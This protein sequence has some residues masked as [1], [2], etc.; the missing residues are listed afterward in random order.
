MLVLALAFLA[1][2]AVLGASTLTLMSAAALQHT[3]AETQTAKRALVEGA[4]AFAFS[5][6]AR[7]G[8]AACTPGSPPTGVKS[9][10]AVTPS[11][12]ILGYSVVACSIG[13][14]SAG[15]AG[16][17]CFFCV[18][19]S[20]SGQ[21]VFVGNKAAVSI[22]APTG[23]PANY[24]GAAI[25]DNIS[26][27][28]G[29]GGICS[30]QQSDAPGTCSLKVGVVAGSSY[31][32][33]TLGSPGS[34][35]QVAS[36]AIGDPL[37][38]TY[39][40]PTSSGL[41]V[42]PSPCGGTLTAGGNCGVNTSITQGIYSAINVSNGQLTL[43]PGVY[44]VT[45][46]FEVSGHGNIS[47]SGVTLFFGCNPGGGSTTWVACPAQTPATSATA[48]TTCSPTSPPS[49]NSFASL[50]GNGNVTL[51]APTAGPYSGLVVYADP[52]NNSSLCVSGSGS[53]SL[54][55]NGALYGRSFGLDIGGNGIASVVSNLVI[56]A[57]NIHVSSLSN[58]LKLGTGGSFTPL[59]CEFLDASLTA[60]PSSGGPTYSGRVVFQTNCP[61]AG[62][63]AVVSLSYSS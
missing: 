32:T 5:D 60:K 28:G 18:L 55:L 22:T 40:A 41:S 47:G 11:G 59:G 36:A 53:G 14:T 38:N 61:G 48:S 51:S 30:R 19:T 35:P 58:G 8:S 13:G 3:D 56:G 24:L 26:F 31:P 10:S 63:P 44:V 46:G 27:T 49:A 12:E 15:G 34:A 17:S 7:P 33:P 43:Q 54:S 2:L 23:A 25:N 16:F 9:G 45:Q 1:L 4:A 21:N 50:G 37:A 62:G 42:Q 6:L 39:Q 29:G 57:V 20:T 52:K